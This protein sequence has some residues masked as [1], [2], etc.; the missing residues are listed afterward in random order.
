[1]A[2]RGITAQEVIL[3]ASIQAALG[4]SGLCI[5]A[6]ERGAHQGRVAPLLDQRRARPDP[7]LILLILVQGMLGRIKVV[8]RAAKHNRGQPPDQIAS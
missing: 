5:Q 6:Q 8:A 7:E 3:G 2:A 4:A 1:M